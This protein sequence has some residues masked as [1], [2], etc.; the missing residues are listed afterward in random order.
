MIKVFI[1]FYKNVFLNRVHSFKVYIKTTLDSLEKIGKSC[2]E[3]R[4]ANKA[5]KLSLIIAALA[6]TR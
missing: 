5:K 3:D 2:E 4:V 1:K 6:K